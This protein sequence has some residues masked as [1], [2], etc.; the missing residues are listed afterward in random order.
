MRIDL[1]KGHFT[2]FQLQMYH[3]QHHPNINI[4]EMC[5]FLGFV[6]KYIEE[7]KCCWVGVG[8]YEYEVFYFLKNVPLS[9]P[10]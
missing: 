6:I 3:L 2:I 5:T 4:C 8:N 7:D 9:F 1:L 10:S